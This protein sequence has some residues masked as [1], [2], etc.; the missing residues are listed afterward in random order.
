MPAVMIRMLDALGT[1]ALHVTSAEQ[2][3]VLIRQAEMILKSAEDSVYEASDLEDIRT[4]Y[5][6]MV[7]VNASIDDVD[8]HSNFP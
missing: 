4:R 3:T 7:L 6:R 2:R 5:R 8:E 1:V